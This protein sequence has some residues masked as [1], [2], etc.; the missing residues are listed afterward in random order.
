MQLSLALAISL[1]GQE[2]LIATFVGLWHAEGTHTIASK[3]AGEV[4]PAHV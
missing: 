4:T 2:L 3:F 1:I